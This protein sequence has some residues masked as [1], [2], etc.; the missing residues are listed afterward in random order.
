MLQL[1]GICH[2]ELLELTHLSLRQ[3]RWPN[4]EVVALLVITR[5][6]TDRERVIPMSAELFHV[7]AEIIRRHI[8]D[9]RLIPL[10]RRWPSTNAS[11]ARCCRSGRKLSSNGSVADARQVCP[12]GSRNRRAA[13]GQLQDNLLHGHE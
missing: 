11:T 1:T 9:G 13:A 7:I 12:T 2:E 3:Y 5:S 8:R 4:G 10:V 6:K